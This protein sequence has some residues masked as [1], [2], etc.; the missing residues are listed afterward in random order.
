MPHSTIE[1]PFEE[2]VFEFAFEYVNRHTG[3][4]GPFLLGV[5]NTGEII[6][7]K[8][9]SS[10]ET[11]QRLSNREALLVDELKLSGYLFYDPFDWPEY[12]WLEW[13]SIDR[14]AMERIMGTAFAESA[15]QSASGRSMQ[16][17]ASWSVMI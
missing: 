4:T 5:D 15:F 14:T 10:D 16:F 17:P 2:R 1:F 3:A 11:D 13:S 8:F 6:S 12:A 7:Q 9:R